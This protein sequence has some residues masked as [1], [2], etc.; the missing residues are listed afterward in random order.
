MFPLTGV[1]VFGAV[2]QLLLIPHDEL[3]QGETVGHLHRPVLQPLE[4]QVIHGVADWQ[5]R[6]R[7]TRLGQ[8]P[9]RNLGEY[10]K[11]HNSPAASCRSGRPWESSSD[12]SGRTG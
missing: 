4:D 10:K 5:Q 7:H 6:D 3:R 8:R 11:T 2:A 1:V 9:R 12:P